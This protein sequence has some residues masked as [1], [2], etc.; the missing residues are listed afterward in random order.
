MAFLP[1]CLPRTFFDSPSKFLTSACRYRRPTQ[2]PFFADVPTCS[3][4]NLVLVM[5]PSKIMARS[6]LCRKRSR[7][8]WFDPLSLSS[9]SACPG[10]KLDIE[11]FLL[12][13]S[14]LDLS[15]SS[16]LLTVSIPLE[17]I[18]DY[19]A[20]TCLDALVALLYGILNLFFTAF[21]IIYRKER[22]W[23]REYLSFES[24]VT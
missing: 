5:S 8:I 1:D 11:T 2:Q 12:V 15:F 23:S 13:A 22:G 7:N 6:L 20:N 9:S 24:I 14:L 3:L 17:S 16:S 4:K 19:G 10:Q 21:P 18:R